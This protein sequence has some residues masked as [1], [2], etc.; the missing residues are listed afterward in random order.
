MWAHV[1]TQAERTECEQLH[2]QGSPT[3]TFTADDTK[4]PATVKVAKDPASIVAA[5]TQDQNA[6]L[7]GAGTVG[8]AGGLTEVGAGTNAPEAPATEGRIQ[9]P[10]SSQTQTRVG[11]TGPQVG[12]TQ[13]D[14]R[15]N[16]TRFNYM[17][18]SMKETHSVLPPLNGELDT[19][20]KKRSLLEAELGDPNREGKRWRGAHFLGAGTTGNCTLWVQTDENE[21]IE[22]VSDARL[23][24]T[25]HDSLTNAISDSL[26]ET[27]YQCINRIGLIPRIGGTNFLVRLP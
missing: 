19:A 3:N 17:P 14:T 22:E 6:Q 27:S 12:P 7:A 25:S 8:D 18:L 1:A 15:V 10:A 24:L 9:S 5:I 26:S 21:N 13:T 4:I 11:A 16:T 2:E 23:V 20:Q